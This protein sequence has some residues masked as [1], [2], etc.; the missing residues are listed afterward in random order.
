[1]C[2]K[3]TDS[4]DKQVRSLDDQEVTIR[5][6][7]TRLEGEDKGFPLEIVKESKSAF[8]PGRPEYNKIM[9]RVEM[10]EVHSIM[11]LDPTRLSR[12]PE[13]SGR[14][15]QRLADGRLG[16]V[17]TADL[18]RYSRNDTALLLMLTLEGAMSWKDS[19]DKGKRVSISMTKKAQE[20]GSIGPAP[21]GYRN[22]GLVKGNKWMEID[23]LTGPKVQRLFTLAATG[24]HSLD[25][26]CKEGN[27][28]GLR[29]RPNKN[30]PNGLQLSKTM[31][32]QMIKN[33]A[34]KGVR[35][36]KGKFYAGKHPPLVKP[37]L[38]Q[39]AQ[40]ELTRRSTNSPR[41]KEPQDGAPFVARGCMTCGV[42]K[43]YMMS[44]YIA[45]GTYII[46]ECKGR[47]MHCQ[48]CINQT[49]VLEQ[50]YPSI[51]AL[52][53]NEDPDNLRSDIIDAFRERQGNN[54]A[55]RDATEKELNAITNSIGSLFVQRDDAQR[56][57]ALEAVDARIQSLAARKGELELV[58]SGMGESCEEVVE[59]ILRCFEL[60]KLALEAVKYGS[61]T[62]KQVI[63]KSL[64]SNYFVKSKSLIPEWRSPFL[65]KSQ[66]RGR[67]DWLPDLDSNQ[68]PSR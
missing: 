8:H 28:L 38:W 59:Q 19:A 45:K 6:A 29:S 53:I 60:Q 51:A 1:M 14:L 57:G 32:H 62:V 9:K 2:R 54:E 20:G 22:A 46:Y 65:E 24:C 3:S 26:L 68:E 35:S 64:A 41:P 21:I 52:E 42:C 39:R 67:K 13:D 23:P 58:L 40:G 7:Y 27:K 16:C 17:L 43:K 10:G 31:M 36:Y 56:L 18:K 44:A 55:C 50:L 48:N 34:Y 5:E 25:Q 11:V 4:E 12:N 30:N 61:P 15:I 66:N 37:E 49:K 63:L 47:G 33:P